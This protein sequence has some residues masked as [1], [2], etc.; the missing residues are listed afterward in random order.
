MNND[1]NNKSKFISEATHAR[2]HRV[3]IE[4]VAKNVGNEGEE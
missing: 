3:N 4:R 2:T 1:Y